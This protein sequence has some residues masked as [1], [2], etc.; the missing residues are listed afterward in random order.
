MSYDVAAQS[1]YLNL[2]QKHAKESSY[3]KFIQS[4]KRKKKSC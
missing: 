2:Q 1:G 4:G 3:A